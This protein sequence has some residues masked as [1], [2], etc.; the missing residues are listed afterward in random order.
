[1]TIPRHT[2]IG[3]ALVAATLAAPPAAAQSLYLMDGAAGG[4]SVTEI[5][6][7]PAGPCAYPNGPVVSG[8]PYAIAGVCPTPGPAL[9]P[10][11]GDVAVD[12][13]L[14]EVYVTDGVAIARY[15]AAGAL[16]S[17]FGVPAVLGM[18]PLTGLGFDSAGG[19]LWITDGVM[20]A[21]LLPTVPGACGAPGIA[22]PAFPAP[23]AAA[24]VTD[25]SWDPSTGFLFTC[26]AAGFIA[27]VVPGGGLAI[28]PYPA[29]GA[30]FCPLGPLTGIAVNTASVGALAAPT[31]YV[32]DGLLVS[33]E[34]VGGGPAPA[35][36]YTPVPCF[37]NPTPF[38]QG[39]AFA[40][41]PITYGKGGDP[42]G[43]VP[44]SIGA[45]GQSILPNPGFAVTLTGA[46]PASSA[47]LVVGTGAACPPLGLGGNPW[48]VIPFIATL[49]PIPTGAIGAVT[50]PAPLPAPGALPPGFG[51]FMQWVVSKST[52][53]FQVSEGLELTTALP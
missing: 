1:M 50:L 15:S 7:P 45:L 20:I 38:S 27:A 17:G 52:G 2:L 28:A 48:L 41:R 33:H 8:F 35:S 40:A 34:V 18:G 49:G 22:F 29:G 16:L 23:A 44:P 21:G 10:F 5:T 9:G 25:V 51:L 26:D 46:V 31:L 47:F 14:D 4:L 6:G 42:T 11:L 19:I 37:P 3:A 12:K 39:L 32:T 13:V 36:F 30:G 53:G 24:P 43:L